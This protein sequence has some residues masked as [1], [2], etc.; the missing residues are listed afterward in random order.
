MVLFLEP[1]VRGGG[2]GGQGEG[3]IPI[4]Q[5]RESRV[6]DKMSRG[7]RFPKGKHDVYNVACVLSNS[8]INISINTCPHRESLSKGNQG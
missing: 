4:S 7:K 5:E 1:N 3:G 6:T 8:H 2:G